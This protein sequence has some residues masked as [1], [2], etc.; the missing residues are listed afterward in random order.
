VNLRGDYLIFDF[1]LSKELKRKDLVEPP[2]GF[3]AT[4]LTGSRRYMAPEVVSCNN[5]GFSADV[6]AFA[7]LLWETMSL[8]VPYPKL[9]RNQHFE[10][11]V[12][13]GK[14]PHR[15][16]NIMP[17][18]LHEML[19]HSWSADP[20]KRPS[21]RSICEQLLCEIAERKDTGLGNL[22]ERTK[23]LM[24]RSHVSRDDSIKDCC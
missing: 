13:K 15:I 16:M 4:G 10:Q 12:L 6:Y 1:G 11:V 23:Y 17:N 5:Y 3:E 20:L 19:E 21:F 24:D 22:E 14:R 8:K 7:I 18:P 2:D 9:T